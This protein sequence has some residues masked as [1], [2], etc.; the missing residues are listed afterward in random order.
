MGRPRLKF[1][2][3]EKFRI[4]IFLI[5]VYTE[6]NTKYDQQPNVSMIDQ[7]IPQRNAT[8]CFEHRAEKMKA[9]EISLNSRKLRDHFTLR[10][11]IL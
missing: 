8:I 10:S 2:Q 5:E 3:F 6:P 9:I 4:K 11:R 7:L 1:L